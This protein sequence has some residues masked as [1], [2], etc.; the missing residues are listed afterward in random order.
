MKETEKNCETFIEDETTLRLCFPKKWNAMTKGEIQE[1]LNKYIE[2]EWR[3]P[4]VKP[5]AYMTSDMLEGVMR[6]IYE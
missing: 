5:V 6:Y 2:E 1:I 4:T 3:K